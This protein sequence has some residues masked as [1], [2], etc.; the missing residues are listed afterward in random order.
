MPKQKTEELGSLSK[1]E[2]VK[3]N[4]LYSRGRDA[5]GSI[6]NLSK[7][8]GLSKKKVEKFLQTKKLNTKFGPPIRRFRRLQV[9]SNY[10]NE[11][12]FMHLAFVDKLASQNNG[13]K[14]FLVAVGFFLRFVRIQKMKTKYAK[15]TFQAF[16][17]MISRK[18][19]LE[20]LWV[21]KGT[22]YGGTFKKFCRE[23][24]IKVYSTMSQTKSAFAERAIQ[25][26]KHIIY[27]YI[28]DHSETTVPKLLQFVSTLNCHKNRSIGKSPR[29]VKNS[30]FLSIL[31]KKNS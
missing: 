13:V 6:Q 5:Y 26:L 9:F 10:T 16:R 8:S 7:A 1:S 18:P 22:K 30:D 15:D 31:Y 11:V 19:I 12:W 24:N 17:K 3:V 23:K 28:E 14:Y 20:K 21:D 25:S 29:D 4:R 2:K 27:R